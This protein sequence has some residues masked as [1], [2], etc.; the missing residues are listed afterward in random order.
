MLFADVLLARRIE[1]AEAANARGCSTTGDG[2][3][4]AVLEAAG[5]CA[6]FAGADSPLTQAVGLGL[7]GPVSDD[8]LNAVECFFRSRGAKVSID[9]CPLADPG[10]PQALSRRGYRVSE[11]NNVLVK[12]LAGTEIVLTPRARRATAGEKDLWAY[13]VGQGFFELAELTTEELNVGRA[14]F[15]MP[16]AICHLAVTGNGELAGGAASAVRQ[17]LAT[18]FADSIVPPFRRAGLHRELIAARLN[19]A[20]AQ[21]CDMATAS[22]LP[23]GIS[24]RNYERLGFEVVYTKVTMVG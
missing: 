14:I 18:L 21:D 23:G 3:A 2:R 4:A 19:E 20:L 17:G 1:A 15:A 13:T 16:G 7:R 10:F 5:G 22:T 6:I 11:F 9:L 24:Q 12:R 8:E